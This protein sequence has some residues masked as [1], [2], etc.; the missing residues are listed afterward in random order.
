MKV[1]PR[2]FDLPLPT[3]KERIIENRNKLPNCAQKPMNIML[4][5][6]L[7]QNNADL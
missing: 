7:L 1:D 5:L 4:I 6:D 3:P 2:I